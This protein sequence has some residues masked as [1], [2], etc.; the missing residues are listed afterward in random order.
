VSGSD[1]SLQRRIDELRDLDRS[2]Q[3]LPCQLLH[4]DLHP[5]VER[6]LP[7]VLPLAV[8]AGVP[9]DSRRE[10]LD[11]AERDA[12][13]ASEALVAVKHRAVEVSTRPTDGD[14]DRLAFVGLLVAD[15]VGILRLGRHQALISFYPRGACGQN[16]NSINLY[17]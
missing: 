11:L 17:A 5:P 6:K 1:S 12:L 14:D 9:G 2:G 7:V 13:S 3:E 16:M 10:L 15:A 8:A 4:D